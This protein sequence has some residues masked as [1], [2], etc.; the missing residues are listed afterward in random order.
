MK[1]ILLVVLAWTLFTEGLFAQA[2]A[3]SPERFAVA[4]KAFQEQDQ[5]AP[6]PKNAILF[7][8]SSIFRQWKDLIEQMAPFPVFNRAF[9]GSRTADVLHYMDQVVLPYSPKL[10]VYYCGSNDVNAKLAPAEIADGF[11]Q[12]AERVHA[13]LPETRLL[14]VSILRAPQKMD[15]WDKV[16]EANRLVREFCARDKRLGFVDANPAVFDAEGKPRM[17]L[18]LA[19]KLHYKEPA[20]VGFTAIIKPEVE[21][22]WRS[23][24]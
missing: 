2:A 18:Y 14:Y 6:P 24:K 19:D 10:I 22:V 15:N 20:Y 5:V 7:I 21:K 1:R 13:K 3:V 9:G 16:D 23:V 12:F 8:G 4:I 17:D 11:I